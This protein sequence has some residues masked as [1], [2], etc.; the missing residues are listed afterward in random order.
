MIITTEVPPH[1]RFY[2]AKSKL[3][4]SG[5]TTPPLLYQTVIDDDPELW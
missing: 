5:S 1:T 2:L 4:V 3:F